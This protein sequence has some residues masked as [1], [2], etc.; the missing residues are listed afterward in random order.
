MFGKILLVIILIFGAM[1]FLKPEWIE[2]IFTFFFNIIKGISDALNI[3]NIM[4]G[5]NI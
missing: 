4:G 2:V 5:I 3:F 1:F